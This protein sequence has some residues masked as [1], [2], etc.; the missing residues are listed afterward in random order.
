[1]RTPG[2]KADLPLRWARPKR[3]VVLGLVCPC[4]GREPSQHPHM[5]TPGAWAVCPCAGLDPSARWRWG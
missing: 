1:V 4:P 5:G 3:H 2:A